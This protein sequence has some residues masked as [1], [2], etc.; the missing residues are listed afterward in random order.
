[1]SNVDRIRDLIKEHERR[2]R[3]LEFRQAKQGIGTD[4]A[5]IIEI[6]DIKD[7]VKK[8]RIE[9]SK[10]EPD[11][12]KLVDLL[13]SGLH[14]GL[15]LWED[16]SPTYQIAENKMLNEPDVAL[17]HCKG[18]L[19]NLNKTSSADLKEAHFHIIGVPTDV[20]KSGTFDSSTSVGTPMI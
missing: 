11:G 5:T 20:V 9:L 17:D 16:V 1:M 3:E 2:L 19:K 14:N 8:L 12:K 10:F 13:N 6:E 18:V 4:P 7:K 15:L